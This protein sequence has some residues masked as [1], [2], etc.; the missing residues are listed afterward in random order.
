MNAS[1][2]VL[3]FDAGGG[4]IRALQIEYSGDRLTFNQLARFD[5]G[6][7]AAGPGLYWDILGLYK[8]LKESLLIASNKGVEVTSFGIDTWGNDFALLDRSGYLMENPFCYRDKRTENCVSYVNGLI[9]GRDIFHLNGIQQVRMN[10]MYQLVSLARDRAYIFD[11]ADKLLFVPDLLA[12]YLTGEMHSEYTMSTISQLYSYT[13]GNWNFSL[14]SRLGVPGKLFSP[15]IMPGTSLGTMLPS[16][17]R[18]IGIKP[19]K[20]TAVGSHDT[21]SAVAA[22]PAP[23]GYPLYISSGTWSIVGTETDAPVINDDTYAFNCSNEGGVNDRI[24]LLKNVMGLWILQEVQRRFAAEGRRYTF[25]ELSRLAED[26]MP[27]RSVIDP[28]DEVFYEP[29]DMPEVIRDYC[30]RTGQP[31]PDS[32]GSITRTVLESLAFKYRYVVDGLDR[33]T[34]TR[35]EEIFVVGGGAKNSLLCRFTAASCGRPVNAGPTEATALGNGLVQLMSLGELANYREARTLVKRSFPPE[36]HMPCDTER[37]EEE[38][39]RFL[40]VTGLAGLPGNKSE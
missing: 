4:S 36:V 15:V 5:N 40:A 21:A 16:V 29:A 27:F 1:K 14:M 23:E 19:I 33:L 13:S 8:N 2:S 18:E 20:L 3:A 37:W 26:A 38:Y 10:T 22:V 31:V 35:H 12:Y 34:G 11:Y 28:D 17:C 6:P 32:D 9:S 39:G 24:R 25:E 30:R 7:V